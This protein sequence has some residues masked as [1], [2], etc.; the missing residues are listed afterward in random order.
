M[1]TRAELAAALGLLG[2]AEV[3]LD[4]AT[5]LAERAG[6]QGCEVTLEVWDGMPHVFQVKAPQSPE[7][8][9]AFH[10]GFA[11]LLEAERLIAE[12]A[13]RYQP[14]RRYAVRLTDTGV[15]QKHVPQAVRIAGHE[16]ARER[17]ERHITSG[18]GGFAACRIGLAAVGGDRHPRRGRRA[19]GCGATASVAQENVCH[20][21]GVPHDEVG[22]RAHE[23][24]ITSVVCNGRIT[25]RPR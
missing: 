12:A 5:R 22:I 20:T 4:D 9:T 25:C 21:V 18:E 16:I 15:A 3:L 11:P 24:N 23:H 8:V 13:N 17:G 14:C 7:T 6:V 1:R 2:D 19:P 10:D